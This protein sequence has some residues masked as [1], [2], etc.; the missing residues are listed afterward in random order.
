ML[1]RT[2]SKLTITLFFFPFFISCFVP[3]I[4]ASRSINKWFPF[5]DRPESYVTKNGSYV[6]PALFITS[7]S[8]AFNN[9]SGNR[10][11]PELWGKYD[12]QEVIAGLA[13]VRAAQG[14]TYNPFI[15][16][17]GY[18]DWDQKKLLFHV[19]GKIRSRG[20]VFALEK[21][22]FETDFSVGAFL[23][24]MHVDTSLLYRFDRNGSHADALEA[25]ESEVFMLDRVRRQVHRDLCLKGAA[26]SKAGF[27]DLDLH[28]RWRR[29]WDHKYKIRGIDLTLQTGVSIP[30]GMKRDEDYPS[31]V[32]VGTNGHWCWYGDL[33]AELELKQNWRFG[34]MAGL[35]HQVH[36]T[37]GGTR[38]PY[39]AEPS[40][41]GALV[42]DVCISPGM[43]L[44]FAPYFTL[45]NLM[46]GLHAQ[47]RYTYRRHSSDKL[48][49]KRA[50][51]EV[52]SYLEASIA[53]SSDICS[54]ASVRWSRKKLSRW[55]SHYL[56][57]QTVYNSVDAMKNWWLDP[58]I[59]AVFDYAFSGR[60]VCKS[61][62]FTVG[63][64]LYF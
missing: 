38:L 64:E 50:C 33:V 23:P 56:T 8:T 36:K 13:A 45:E 37:H 9:G 49:D 44:K 11:I 35:M 63:V 54:S 40:L 53:K 47:F 61:H 10:G 55:V 7:A 3:F 41:F 26:W 58:K 2:K 43:T 18:T 29:Y 4:G 31:S 59:Y 51:K 21:N 62:Q 19:D 46:D 22:I 52:L 57:L 42:G 24:V 1:L 28:L 20:I 5:L 30:T 14:E 17:I 12:L 27:G 15:D 16:E 32:P 34:V 39:H 25:T 60:N 6:Y 48:K